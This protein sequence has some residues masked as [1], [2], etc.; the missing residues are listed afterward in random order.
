MLEQPGDHWM[1][2]GNELV[3][4]C[5]GAE[6]QGALDADLH[7]TIALGVAGGRVLLRDGGQ[8]AALYLA[9]SRACSMRVCRA[10]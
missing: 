1:V 6:L 5:L 4:A 8:A 10:G 9:R 7:A 2:H 3:K